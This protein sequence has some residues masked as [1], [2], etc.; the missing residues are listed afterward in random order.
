M[1]FVADK[2]ERLDKFLVRMMPTFSRTKLAASVT[3]GGVL[4]DG[5]AQRPSFMLS[6]GSVVDVEAEP[7]TPP[8]DLTPSDMEIQ[9]LYEDDDLLV[10]NKPRG[11]AVHP[12]ETLKEPSLVNVLL[13]RSHG[14]SSAAGS[15]RPGIVHRLDKETTGAI[16]VAKND[17]AHLH[18]AKQI[19]GKSAE[20]RYVVVVAGDLMQER[21]TVDAPIGR[22]PRHRVKMAVAA[23]GRRAVTH[24]RKLRRLDAGT[25]A[26]ARLETGRTHQIRVHALAVGHPV[27]GD[28]LYAPKEWQDGPMQLHAAFMAFEHPIS[29]ERIEVFAPPP[30]DFLG[31]GWVERTDLDPF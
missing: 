11:L 8:H 15:F 25:L 4:V 23:G 1:Q 10:V 22:D 19:E 28:R 9:V 14:L 16:V 17:V 6:P 12:A 27:L 2:A 5:R 30:A 24:F 31:A 13:G 7:E 18:L 3:A 20:R 21:F 26:A 29:G